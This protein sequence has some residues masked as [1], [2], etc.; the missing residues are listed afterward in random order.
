MFF[1]SEA[2]DENYSRLIGNCTY[3]RREVQSYSSDRRIIVIDSD[4]DVRLTESSRAP[5]GS[6]IGRTKILGL[7]EQKTEVLLVA[8]HWQMGL[9][10]PVAKY[11]GFWLDSKQ[12]NAPHMSRNAVKVYMATRSLTRFMLDA[13]DPELVILLATVVNLII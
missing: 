13:E 2:S 8:G 12:R 1:I 9:S 10:E 4:G 11:L 5:Q 3:I 7:A 6:I